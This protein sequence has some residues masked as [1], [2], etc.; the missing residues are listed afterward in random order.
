[1]HSV[2]AGMAMVYGLD[3]WSS[4]SSWEK[5]FFSALLPTGHSIFGD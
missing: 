3:G 2:G 4:F 1:M 5:R